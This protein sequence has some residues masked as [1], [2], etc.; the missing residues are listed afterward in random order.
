M[1]PLKGG[2]PRE[3]GVA[4]MG[5]PQG[6]MRVMAVKCFTKLDSSIPIAG[7]DLQCRPLLGTGRVRVGGIGHNV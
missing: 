6:L 1:R 4:L 7:W 3:R 2:D 5:S